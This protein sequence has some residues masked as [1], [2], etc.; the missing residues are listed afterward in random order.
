M[1]FNLVRPCPGCPFTPGGYRL[2]PQRIT[3]IVNALERQT[4]ACHE[5]VHRAQPRDARGR[6]MPAFVPSHCAGA[7]LIMLREGMWGDMQQLAMR[8]GLFEPSRLDTTAET[9]PTLEACAAANGG[10]VGWYARRHLSTLEL[11]APSE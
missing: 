8:L 11:H 3:E 9:Y 1:R 5:S 2:D 7:L 10:R 6:F 4:F